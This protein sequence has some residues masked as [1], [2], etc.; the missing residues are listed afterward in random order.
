MYQYTVNTT[1]ILQKIRT[2]SAHTCR[3]IENINIMVFQD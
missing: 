1:Q 2:K 3:Q